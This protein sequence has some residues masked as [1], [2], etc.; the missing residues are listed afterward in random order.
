MS[1][2]SLKTI[3]PLWK[4]FE[5]DHPP[6][7]PSE[8]AAWPPFAGL[9]L[10][11]F[12]DLGVSSPMKRSRHPRLELSRNIRNKARSSGPSTVNMAE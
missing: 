11:V 5:Q 8:R 12:E 2:Q 9:A 10:P 4:L 6:A 1:W 3:L 7:H